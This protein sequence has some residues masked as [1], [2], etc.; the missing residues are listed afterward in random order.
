MFFLVFIS[1]KST[2]IKMEVSYLFQFCWQVSQSAF[3]KHSTYK[4]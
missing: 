4:G 2:N 3:V 1:P